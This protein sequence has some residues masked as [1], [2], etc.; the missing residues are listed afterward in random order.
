MPSFARR[1]FTRENALPGL[2]RQEWYYPIKILS[3]FRSSR[4][5][6]RALSAHSCAQGIANLFTFHGGLYVFAKI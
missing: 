2:K 4:Q 1:N 5:S 3:D 6:K